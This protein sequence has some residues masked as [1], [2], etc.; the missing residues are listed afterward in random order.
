MK[1]PGMSMSVLSGW[2]CTIIIFAFLAMYLLRSR[3]TTIQTE[4]ASRTNP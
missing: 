1:S 4:S 2:I 3:R